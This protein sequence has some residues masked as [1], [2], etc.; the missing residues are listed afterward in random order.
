MF[1]PKSI[2]SRR[3]SFPMI[4]YIMR[5][6][7][8]NYA[9]T[10]PV[11]SPSV[12]AAVTSYLQSG[13]RSPGRNFEGLEDSSI[14][15][16]AR[17]ALGEL[18]GVK[19]PNRIIFTSGV[20]ASLNM[21][22]NGIVRPGDHVLS[23]SVEHN[24]V[25]RPLALLQERGVVEVTWMR[26][27][28]DGF[29]DP[30]RVHESLRPNSRL[31]VMTHASNVLGTILPYRECFAEA[32]RHG[33]TT[34]L[35]A[36]QTAGCI[37][38]R[39]GPETDAIA[40]AGHKGLGGLAGVGGFALGDGAPERISPWLVGGTGSASH[41]LEQ[42]DFLPDKFE[43]GTPNTVGIASL[44]ASVKELLAV[45]ITAIR[46]REMDLT[47]RFIDKVRCLPVVVCGTGDAERSM[48]VVSLHVPGHDMGRLARRLYEDHGVLVRSGLHCSP[49]AHQTA[50]TF[51]EGTLRFSFGRE[52]T[53]DDID[54]GVDALAQSL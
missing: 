23:T 14:A 39:M 19:K 47:A 25:A 41:L 30:C 36:A 26:C 20:T 52:T 53:P 29:L 32:K 21:L 11:T 28:P 46:D 8:L 4:E 17:L 24:A 50:G 31:L 13:H 22:L 5:E 1:R 35:D 34:I 51:P 16:D 33:L 48:P 15:L 18:F 10:S 2:W 40:F 45:G 7:Y 3:S 12:V 54:A 9:S 6:I 42:P 43:P 49:L 38:V 27:E 37:E 44:G